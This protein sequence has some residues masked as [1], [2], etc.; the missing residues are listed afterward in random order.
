[1]KTARNNLVAHVACAGG[2]EVAGA[3]APCDRRCIQCEACVKACPHGAVSMVD[4]VARVDR[5][6]CTGCGLCAMACPRRIIDLVPAHQ[7]I[8]VRCSNWDAGAVAR[9]AC[10]TSCIGCGMC[11]KKCPAGAIKVIDNCAQIDQSLCISCGMCAT[12]CPCGVIHDAFG[13]VASE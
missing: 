10:T 7:N 5:A 6:K 9:K 1:M 13:I 12:V 2:C 11:E 8:T 3:A 4:G